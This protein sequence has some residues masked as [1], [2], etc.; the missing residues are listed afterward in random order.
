MV[1]GFYLGRS[2]TGSAYERELKRILE[3]DRGAL[4]DFGKSL[5]VEESAAYETVLE[6]PFLVIRAAGSFGSDLV[7]LRDDFS[8]P[9]E[10][11]SS[12]E[13]TI[14]FGGSRLARQ[15]DAFIRDCSRARI[16][17]VYAFRLKDFRG[18]C[19]RLFRLPTSVLHRGFAR[20]LHRVIPEVRTTA[21]GNFAMDWDK[22]LP[23]A[24]F[25]ERVCRS[26][27]DPAGESRAGLPGQ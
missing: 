8:F 27:E 21:A 3:G 9:I 22:G 15:A 2:S 18:D 24:R 11:K 26:I 4:A 23:L 19:W 13:G 5:S 6:R 10:V 7:A 14:R 16:V 1:K 17:P 12:R 25:L 20:Q